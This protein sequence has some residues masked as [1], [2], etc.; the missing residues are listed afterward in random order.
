[1]KI[2]IK[3]VLRFF[4]LFALLLSF[5]FPIRAES[6]ATRVDDHLKDRVKSAIIDEIYDYGYFV[7]Y[8]SNGSRS[9]CGSV[10][11]MTILFNPR[12][13]D[14]DKYG[15]VIYELK[16]YGKIYRL[17]YLEKG[18]VKLD[19]DPENGF[20]QSQPSHKTSFIDHDDLSSME[21][22]WVKLRAELCLAPKRTTI[23]AAA[24]RQKARTGFSDYLS[25][26][27]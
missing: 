27:K 2:T 4:G 13:D 5:A 19:G 20:P 12:Y 17:Y 10:S 8:A 25:K 26:V 18:V 1:M 16:P 15:E 21:R 7:K 14:K 24:K 9:S 23:M 22:N 3:D 6:G 11:N